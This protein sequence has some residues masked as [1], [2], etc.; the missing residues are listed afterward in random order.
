[1]TSH[2]DES[3]QIY[4]GSQDRTVRIWDS[5]KGTLVQSLTAHGHWINNIALSS[6]F[7]L[8]TG[9]LDHSKEVPETEEAKRAKA[10]ER[11]EKAVKINGKVAE[12]FVS[13]SDDFTMYLW[14]PTNNGNKPVARLLGHQN[15]VNQC[16]FS[17]DGTMIASAGWDNHTVSFIT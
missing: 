17:P 13:A 14:D 15:K 16:A 6:D 3:R 11:F 5:V 10:K 1:M 9:Y 8:R 4:T 12:R 7:V 2:T